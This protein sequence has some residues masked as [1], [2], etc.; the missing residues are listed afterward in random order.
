MKT[1]CHSTKPGKRIRWRKHSPQ[2]FHWYFLGLVFRIKE[3]Q[4]VLKQDVIDLCELRRLCFNGKY[5]QAIN[6]MRGEGIWG[7]IWLMKMNFLLGIP[8]CNSYRG[9]CWKILLGYLGPKRSEWADTL[10]KKRQLYRQFISKFLSLIFL[11]WFGRFHS[12]CFSA[13]RWVRWPW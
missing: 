9:L 3:F 11:L 13:S 5:H 10:T 4:E 12:R 6:S 8:D 7:R 1:K 2:T